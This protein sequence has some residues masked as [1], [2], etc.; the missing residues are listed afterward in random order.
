MLTIKL[1]SGENVKIE[2]YI[3][4]FRFDK[5]AGILEVSVLGGKKFYFPVNHVLYFYSDQELKY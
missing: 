1:T 5:E 3:E 4:K 2:K